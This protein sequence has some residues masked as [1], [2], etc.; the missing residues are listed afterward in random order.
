MALAVREYDGAG[1]LRGV[2]WLDGG[3]LTVL[4]VDE[5]TTIEM[6]QAV[7]WPEDPEGMTWEEA[8][9]QLVEKQNLLTKMREGPFETEDSAESLLSA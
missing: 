1:N 5:F 8:L 7:G 3:D 9:T 2:Y 6:E 4:G